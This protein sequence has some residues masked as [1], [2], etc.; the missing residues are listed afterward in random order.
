MVALANVEGVINPVFFRAQSSLNERRG[1]LF[2]HSCRSNIFIVETKRR[3][4]S[5]SLGVFFASIAL[6]DQVEW[7]RTNII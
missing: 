6:R 1:V 2:R 4:L 5:S 3:A 7:S